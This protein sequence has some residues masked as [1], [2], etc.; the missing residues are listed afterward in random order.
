MYLWD[1]IFVEIGYGKRGDKIYSKITS[2]A[3]RVYIINRT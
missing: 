2:V 3:E 1:V